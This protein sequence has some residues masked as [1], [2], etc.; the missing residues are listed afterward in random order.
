[1]WFKNQ[2]LYTHPPPFLINLPFRSLA[3]QDVFVNK[4]L[5]KGGGG[6]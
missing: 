5:K 3:A 6:I 2:L 1:M 4:N